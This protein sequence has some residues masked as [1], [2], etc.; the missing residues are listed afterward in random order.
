M[1]TGVA[2]AKTTLAKRARRATLLAALV[3]LAVPALSLAHPER[4]SYWPDPRPDTAVSPSAGGKVPQARSLASAVTGA[5]PGN[6]RVVCK[7]TGGSVSLDLLEDSLQVARTQG[8][9]LR[10]SQPKI[11][12]T[13]ERAAELRRINQALAQRCQYHSVQPAV[14]ASGNNDR[15]VVL[16]GR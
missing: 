3:L 14:T 15:V 11:V 13:A 4:P 5:G 2:G 16:P 9:R 10:P 1:K 8:F 12:Y 7:G 6:V